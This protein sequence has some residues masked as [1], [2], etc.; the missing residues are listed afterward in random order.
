MT[1]TN[2]P[3]QGF[4]APPAGAPAVP[5]VAP[6]QGFQVPPAGPPA[7]IPGNGNP[8]VGPGQ[9]PGYVVPPLQNQ[10]APANQPGAQQ[11]DLANAIAALN[12]AL[13]A[14][15]QAPAQ[16]ASSPAVDST[17]PSW[18][19][20][21]ANDFDLN[22]VQDPSIRAM[23]S[24]L[25][26]AGKDLDLDRVL[27]KALTYGD[28]ALIDMAYLQEKGGANAGQFAE[29]ARGIVQAV[30]A[31]SE[32]ITA[33][34][35]TLC[36]GEAQWGQATAVF[37]QNAPQ[38]LKVTVSQMLNSTNENFIKAGAKVVAEFGRTSGLVPQNGAA[39]LN[40]AAAGMQGQG[41]SKAQFQEELRKLKPDTPG[42]EQS[43]EALFVRRSLGKR[44]GL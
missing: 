7:G 40:S 3:T 20:T 43:R 14:A 1:T 4:Q 28:I 42:F 39:L 23:A 38:E 13:V 26:T 18:M 41:L 22:Q 33:E 8:I 32:A 2:V 25:Q 44:T 10:P 5:P 9:K 21:S 34:I 31:K 11:P 17:R 30:T 37:N 36:G 24:I 19:D 15:G 6:A 35:H 29:I 27:G 12:A 16:A